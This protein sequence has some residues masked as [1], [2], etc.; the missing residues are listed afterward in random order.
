M[1]H[2]LLS[3]RQR[4]HPINSVLLRRVASTLVAEILHLPGYE[5]GIR[6]VAA[7][8]MKRLNR[9][10]LQHEGH[11]DV[12]TF[13]YGTDG[14]KRIHGDIVICV[15]AAVRQ[16]RRFHTEFP[17]ELAR[18]LIHGMLHLLGYDDSR[19]G[20]RRVLKR[21]ENR[22]LRLLSRRFDLSRLTHSNPPLKSAKKSARCSSFP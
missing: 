3:N 12:I 16:A 21:E 14:R 4:S 2:L 18:Y 7:A 1:N 22:L 9:T 6:L 15:D 8:E 20:L 11:T 19:P 17:L 10:Y 13:N 5:V